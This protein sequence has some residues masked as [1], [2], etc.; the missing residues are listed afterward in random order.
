MHTFIIL[1]ILTSLLL[2]SAPLSSNSEID[3]EIC[4]EGPL[5]HPSISSTLHVKKLSLLAGSLTLSGSGNLQLISNASPV[6]LTG[7]LTI[8]EARLK[9]PDRKQDP[10]DTVQVTYVNAS[11]TDPP[12]LPQSE[13][14]WPLSLK[15][16]CAIPATLKIEGADLSSSWKGDLTIEGTPQNLSVFGQLKVDQG[17][18]QFN[19]KPF[20]IK[21]GTVTFEGDPDKKTTLYVT[22]TR[23]FDAVKVDLIL[24][25]TPK[26]PQISFR[27]NPPLPQREILSWILFDR[28]TQEISPFQGR[29]LNETIT[30]LDSQRSEGL[31]LLTKL[32]KTLGIDRF[33]ISKDE[34]SENSQMS[35]QV[36]KYLSD[37]LYI[38]INKSDV[39]R[40]AIEAALTDKIKMEADIGDDAEGRFLIKW[41]RDY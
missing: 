5:L 29:Q 28:G 32:R 37:N 34:R 20:E 40:L 8:E 38:S 9:I 18:F 27:S 2:Y 41:K 19:G 36:G 23:T 25:G 13:S 16:A 7:S 31:D 10:I 11:E 3:I 24:K 33:E 14:E 1:S 15:I 39:S 35:V 6:A 12:Q 26:N 4:I 22:A 30:D 17:S 21:Q